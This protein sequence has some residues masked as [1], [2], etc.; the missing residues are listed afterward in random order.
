MYTEKK[1]VV[2]MES[3]RMTEIKK[4]FKVYEKG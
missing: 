4:L 2:R 1:M 3:K